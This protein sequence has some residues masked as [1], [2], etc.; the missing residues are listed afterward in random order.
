MGFVGLHSHKSLFLQGYKADYKILM[1][2]DILAALFWFYIISSPLCRQVT[3]LKLVSYFNS[4][5]PFVTA[6]A[7]ASAISVRKESEFLEALKNNENQWI[8]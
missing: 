5:I 7:L 6:N 1:W 8:Q 3:L 4:R 2:E